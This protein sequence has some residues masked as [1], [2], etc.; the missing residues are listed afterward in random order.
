MFDRRLITKFDWS[1]LVAVFI[2]LILG[3]LNLYS[4][5][6]QVYQ[7]HIWWIC[8]GIGVM[9]LIV[10]ID[11]HFFLHNAYPFYII[12]LILLLL[13]LLWGK[14]SYEVKRWLEVGPFSF[15]PS[16]FVKITLILSL[17]KYFGGHS[18]PK[19]GYSLQNFGIPFL[20]LIL[21]FGLIVREHLGGAILIT[22][23]FL[24]IISL[25]IRISSLVAIVLT[26]LF[27]SPLAWLSLKGYQRDRILVFLSPL[28]DPLG[29]G[30]H[31]IQS[32]I[33]IG[34]GGFFGKGFLNGTQ[35]QLR[36]LPAQYTDFAFSVWAEEWGFLG[37]LVLILLYLFLILK[38]ID[39][40]W[41]AKDKGGM[42]IAF[43]VT[44][45]LFWQ[46]AINL[47]MV[48]GILPV[49][50]IPLPF[51]SYGGSATI[52]IL[53]AVGLLLNVSMRKY[54]FGPSSI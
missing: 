34:S 50:G 42:V 23:I 35:S 26:V 16:E 52:T 38:G 27:L 17:A 30:Y 47:L 6:P 24:S 31:L 25:R 22:L 1:L 5:G 29:S 54:L 18:A 14:G 7:R 43:G 36:F 20:L 3:A 8:L 28:S 37:G 39:I 49:V 51:L 13:V 10:S 44:S 9:V 21:P 4:A 15:Q 12:S 41:K 32:K 2:L 48:M 19:K 45:F 53:A 33:A 40:A 46:M 11:Y